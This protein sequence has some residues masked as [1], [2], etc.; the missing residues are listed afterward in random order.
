MISKIILRDQV[1]EHLLDQMTNGLLEPDKTINLAALARKLDVSERLFVRH[2]P[3]YSNLNS[4]KPYPTE[5]LLL[6]N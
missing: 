5:G 3:N 6:P 4:S 2:L 1:R